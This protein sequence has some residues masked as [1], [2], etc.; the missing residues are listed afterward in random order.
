MTSEGDTPTER[1]ITLAVEA[2]RMVLS[3]TMWGG[4]GAVTDLLAP[5]DFFET[6]HAKIYGHL[7]ELHFN[8]QPTEPVA[9][10]KR[11]LDTGDTGRG[12]NADYL[13]DL[14]RLQAPPEQVGFYA[15]AVLEA[16]EQRH[17][18]ADAARLATA[19]TIPDADQR[20]IAIG[21]ILDEITT[22]AT[23]AQVAAAAVAV[24][25][26]DLDERF[27]ALDWAAGFGTDFSQI[28]WLPGQF[29]ERGQ[30]VALVGDGKVGKSL[31][32]LDWAYRT[33]AG[34]PFLDGEIHKPAR[35]LYLDKENSLRDVITRL[36]ALGADPDSLENL[37]YQQFPQFTGTLDAS[38]AASRELVAL[39]DH[40]GAE[41]VV[42]DTI[43][44]FIEGNENDSS[45]W[46][47]LYQLIHEHLKAR[48]VA[49]LRLDHFGKDDTRGSRGSSAK[50]QDVDGVWELSQYNTRTEPVADTDIIHTTL[51]LAR[52]HTRSG[53]GEDR[54]TIGRRGER[55]RGGA[56]L[57]SR[58]RHL[59]TESGVVAQAVGEVETAVDELV[60]RGV[61]HGMGRDKLKQWMANAGLQTHGNARMAD[62]TKAL[63]AR[64]QGH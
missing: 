23:P 19:A 37:I 53:I 12:I 30:Q 38:A 26:V 35:V 29:M 18:V 39:V 55:R 25:T 11:A 57:H 4:A 51:R 9:V 47:Q 64:H 3:A 5:S 60:A 41:V 36:Q 7:V 56:W 13:H 20:R 58:T 52:T 16:G 40:H 6:R 14:Y 31:F 42:I 50:A 34:L 21:R 46:L 28:D 59:L 63:Q 49:C 45:T 48:G 17:Q 2:E 32:A 10:L 33:A 62:I 15:R 22:R 1:N 8:D 54:F 43:S 44:R 24:D 61:P 27:P